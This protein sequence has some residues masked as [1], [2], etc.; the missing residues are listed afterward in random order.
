PQMRNGTTIAVM[1]IASAMSLLGCKKQ[2]P[3]DIVQKSLRNALRLHAP[4]TTSAMCGANVKGLTNANITS[5]VRKPDGV[6]GTAHISGA[7]WVAPGSPPLCEGDVEFKF[8]F[9]QKSTGPTKRRKT[10]TTW[11]LE[12][13]KLTAVQTRGVTFRPVD[14]NASDEDDD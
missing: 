14:E 6:T 12:H 8:T 13:V 1:A 5:V 9:T 7:P 11:F 2:V 3:T 4:L 10:T